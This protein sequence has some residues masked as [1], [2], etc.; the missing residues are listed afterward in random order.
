MNEYSGE[1]MDFTPDKV[2]FNRVVENLSNIRNFIVLFVESYIYKQR[3]LE[4]SLS[5][6]ELRTQLISY[7]KYYTLKNKNLHKHY[8]K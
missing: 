7:E 4:K 8:K 5:S 2:L 3:C 1:F 6:N